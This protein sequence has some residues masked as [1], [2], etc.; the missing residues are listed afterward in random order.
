MPGTEFEQIARFQSEIAAL[1][2]QV[3][4]QQSSSPSSTTERLPLNQPY[5]QFPPQSEDPT[6]AAIVQKIEEDYNA[7]RNSEH[8][9]EADSSVNAVNQ[10]VE[11]AALLTRLLIDSKAE[12]SAWIERREEEEAENQ[13]SLMLLQTKVAELA[14]SATSHNGDAP[15]SSSRSHSRLRSGGS[16]GASSASKL[17]P[18]TQVKVSSSTGS[19]IPRTPSKSS[20][21]ST[22][23]TGT[24]SQPGSRRPSITPKPNVGNV[25]RSTH[26][27]PVRKASAIPTSIGSASGHS[28]KLSTGKKVKPSKR[29][30]SVG[31]SDDFTVGANS[32]N[33]DP[34][35]PDMSHTSSTGSS[36]FSDDT[37]DAIAQLAPVQPEIAFSTPFQSIGGTPATLS[38][39]ASTIPSVNSSTPPSPSLHSHDSDFDMDMA[40]ELPNSAR[41]TYAPPN[42]EAGTAS[43]SPVPSLAIPIQSP[44][45][46][47]IPS[48]ASS[49][50]PS[51]RSGA[52][53]TNP[54]VPPSPRLITPT[55]S[56]FTS[57]PPS[58]PNSARGDRSIPPQLPDSAPNTA[59]SMGSDSPPPVPDL[60]TSGLLS[61]RSFMES[62]SLPPSVPN[63]ARSMFQEDGEY[64]ESPPPMPTSDNDSGINTPIAINQP[65]ASSSNPS[66]GSAVPKLDFGRFADG[67]SGDAGVG[68]SANPMEESNTSPSSASSSSST[69]G[70]VS[71]SSAGLVRAVGVPRTKAKVHRK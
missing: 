59:R 6:I 60:D 8:V 36:V 30:A 53:S 58:L 61:H 15:V 63:S 25:T 17:L 54:S 18:P 44:I 22:H 52:H 31:S 46:S 5:P 7:Y 10:Q 50:A 41:S 51:P 14:A 34:P 49:M 67:N 56:P 20:N 1:Q 65:V 45:G 16:G 4:A 12:L 47:T 57:H 69:S 66:S 19:K 33:A 21:S 35:I 11:H 42:S 37:L 39:S 70:S 38:G 13:A 3:S 64:L 29:V 2:S 9:Y 71:S 27:S 62:P 68:D 23:P 48:I 55:S 32:L 26:V 43:H 24:E 40:P 28:K